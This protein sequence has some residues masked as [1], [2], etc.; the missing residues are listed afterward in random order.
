MP[1]TVKELYTLSSKNHTSITI[2]KAVSIVGKVIPPILIILGKI[3]MDSW[4]YS[5][6]KGIELVLLS[7][8]RFLNS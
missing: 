6:L 7:N 4:Y 3:H 2:L 8:S 5:N 1:R